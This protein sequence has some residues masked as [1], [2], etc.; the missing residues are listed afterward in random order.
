MGLTA[1][2]RLDLANTNLQGEVEQH[3][4]ARVGQPGITGGGVRSSAATV[5]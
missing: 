3:L 4:P 2:D 1:N 5:C